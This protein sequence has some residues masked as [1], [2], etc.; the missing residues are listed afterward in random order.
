MYDMEAMAKVLV[1][2]GHEAQYPP[3]TKTGS[4][5]ECIPTHEYYAYKKELVG[6][7]SA[8]I[9][10]QHD[11]PIRDHFN[12]VAWSDAILVANHDKKGIMGYV[13]PNTLMEMGL[14]FY[15][16]KPIYLLNPIPDVPWREEILGMKPVV[17]EGD[18]QRLAVLEMA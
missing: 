4:N 10:K 17:L 18:L 13:G 11:Q 12:K 7:P 15:L 14:A 6:D 1:A 8:W 9:W 3:V 2:M 5:G 16:N